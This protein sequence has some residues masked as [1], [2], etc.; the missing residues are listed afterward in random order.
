MTRKSDQAAVIYC[1]V[2]TKKQATEGNGLTSQETRCR[3]YSAHRRHKVVKV[4]YDDVSGSLASRPGFDEML[5]FIKQN[6]ALKPV[7]IIDDISR[8]ARDVKN[9]F[10]L[11]ESIFRAGASL[12]SPSIEFGEDSDSILIEHLL[13]S[14][15][16]HQR[17]KNGEQ[18]ANRMR[19]RMMGG[20]WVHNPPIGY[21]YEKS[22]RGGSELK[23]IEPLA[24]V[25][26]E[27]LE[28][29]AAGR[30]NSK[31]EV[32]RFFESH[33]G[34][35]LC[36]HGFLTN[37]QVHRIMT[38]P[39]YAGYLESKAWGISLRKAQHEGVISFETWERVQA[40]LEG[41]TYA[42]ARR[43]INEDF[44]LR[45]FVTCGCCGHPLTANWSKGRNRK[46]PYYVCRHRGCEKF[47]KSVG[48]DV[49]E[50]A[51]EELLR[52]LVP[53]RGLHDLMLT[54]F[55]KRWAASE[56]KTRERQRELKAEASVLEKKIRATLDLMLASDSPTVISAFERKVE[57]LERKRLLIEERTA[58]CG[59]EAKGFDETFRTAFEFIS[60]PW[61]L[62]ENGS[63]EDKRIVLKLTLADH[64]EYD[65]NGT[66]RTVEIS[67][68]FK[69]LLG[70][71]GCENDLAETETGW[72]ETLTISR[73]L[74]LFPSL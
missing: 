29:Y 15:S 7:V 33:P 9:H 41:R 62:W 26:A 69:V 32:K 16:Q 50:G 49:I 24:S 43:D 67:M 61:N 20:Y 45:G 36:R 48:R 74:D 46:H 5:L 71:C 40:K 42:P 10:N 2:S 22:S 25:I 57:E 13:A 11:K 8:M 65:W 44:P 4:F 37:Q 47:G 63:L 18:A 17:Q 30:F 35:P 12:E 51:Y 34:F 60:N 52:S 31:A 28:G 64:L 56:A 66:V 6:R 19:A 70:K 58:R 27:G 1:R 53:S 23:R 39:L 55:K 14:V 72:A 54:L 38:H 68:P 21:R 73:G 59:T 3:E